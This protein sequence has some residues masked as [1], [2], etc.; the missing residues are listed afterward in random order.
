MPAAVRSRRGGRRET[1]TGLDEPAV[2]RVARDRAARRAAVRPARDRRRDHRRRNRRGRDRARARRGARR[3]RRLRGRDVERLVEADPRRPA[4][5]AD[6]RR[7]A[8]CARRTRSGGYLMSVVAPHLVERLP[9]L[10]PLYRDGPHRPWVVRTG[11]LALLGARAREAERP[12]RAR[13]ARCGSCRSCAPRGCTRRRSTR[14]RWTND[15]RLTIAN[16]R[17]AADARRSRP[18]LRRGHGCPSGWRRRGRRR[19]DRAVS[20]RMIVNATGPWLDRIRRLEDPN[21]SAVDAAEQGRAPG[22]RRRRG[23][24]AQ[25]SRSR[26]TRCASAS[27]SRGRGSCCS[28]RPTPCTRA[29]PRTDRVTDDDV[30]TILV[31]A[32]EAVRDLG[33]V[34]A[35]FWGLRVLPGGAGRDRAGAPRDRLH[36]RADRDAERRRRQA[37]DVPA[38][39]ARRARAARR[40]QSRPRAAA[41][42]RARRGSHRSRGRSTSTRRPARTCCTSTARSRPTC[43]RRRSTIRRCSSRCVP[44]RP[45]LRAQELYAREHEWARTD[46]DVL[47]RRTTAWLA[48]LD[49]E[50]VSE[51]ST[52]DP[53]ARS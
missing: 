39:R 26:T 24:D 12:R 18:Q 32:S 41:A 20:A 22:R 17:G 42:A 49:S 23:L 31:E 50:D 51:V 45:D 27:R 30:R 9:F 6:G 13:S 21:A 35:S 25:P 11:V 38:H 8:S 48:G 52:A 34:R 5:P 40:A 2:D 10:F 36:H 29:S 16:V 7:P 33:Q 44:G 4:L 14:T 46:E 15:G 1:A 19:A 3:P 43:S 37:D 53:A 47:R 28:A